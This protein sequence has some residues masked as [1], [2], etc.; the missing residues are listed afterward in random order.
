M[1]AGGP[2]TSTDSARLG[3]VTITIDTD[4]LARRYGARWALSGVTMHV[5]EATA[6]MVAGRNGAGKS[7]LLRVLATAIRPDRGSATVGGFDVVRHRED[8]RRLTA[9]LAHHNYLY[10]SLTARENLYVVADHLRV[11]RSGV[12]PLLE[13]VGLG[14]R[15][16]DLVSTFS[17]GM[18]K[19][20]SFAR[21]LLQAPRVVL[22]DEPYGA[23][24][25]PGFALVD[26]VIATLKA[27]GATILMATH[28]WERASRLCDLAIVLEQGKVA[29]QGRAAEVTQHEVRV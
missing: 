25:P 2:S 8:V 13:Q 17:A 29:W 9:L 22:L 5:P 24:D 23:L 10:E 1:I 12:L 3:S 6:V 7:T 14:A 4:L 27:S 21:V 19:R 18:R 16:D 28:Q 11:A 15:S 26:T 20:L